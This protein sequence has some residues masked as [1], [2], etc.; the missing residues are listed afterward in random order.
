M[1]DF[2]LSLHA[3]LPRWA[4]NWL[5]ALVVAFQ[6]GA[7]VFA[8]WVVA[9]LARHLVARLTATYALP[10]KVALLSRRVL[11]FIVYGGALL[12]SLERLGVSGMALWAAF[13]GFATVAAVAFFAAWS[14]LSNLFCALLIFTTRTF[15]AGDLVELLESGDK[16][17][18]RGRVVDINLV[19]TT[20]LESGDQTNGTTLQLP[21]SLFF[22]RALRRWHGAAEAGNPPAIEIHRSGP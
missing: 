16:P 3:R 12:W 15:R 17:G 10:A 7:I 4:D 6:I 1:K 18:L 22:Q 13:T 9:R 11:A 20:L 19:Y 14:V 8:A 5:D 2:L 21:N